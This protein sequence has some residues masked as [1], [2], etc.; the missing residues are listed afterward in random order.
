MPYNNTNVVL[1]SFHAIF[2]LKTRAWF[3]K[4]DNNTLLGNNY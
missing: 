2:L 3:P 4:V 1:N